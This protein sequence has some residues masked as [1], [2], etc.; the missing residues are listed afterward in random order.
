MLEAKF[1]YDPFLGNIL[2]I[3]VQSRKRTSLL[4]NSECKSNFKK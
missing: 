1:D 4:E 3:I 2:D